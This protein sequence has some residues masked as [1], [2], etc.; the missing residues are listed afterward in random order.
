[1]G[2]FPKSRFIISKN[3]PERWQTFPLIN[4]VR[5]HIILVQKEAIFRMTKWR[6]EVK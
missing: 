4:T 1:M 2:A 6:Y 5:S 3:L